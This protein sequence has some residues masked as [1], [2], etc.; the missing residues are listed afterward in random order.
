MVHYVSVNSHAI[1]RTFITSLVTY[2]GGEPVNSSSVCKGKF[3]A[4][5]IL[6][7][8]YDNMSVSVI[9]TVNTKRVQVMGPATIIDVAELTLR[10]LDKAFGKHVKGLQRGVR[11]HP[12]GC[13][14]GRQDPEQSERLHVRQ[15]EVRRRGG[16]E[17]HR[18]GGVR[19][20]DRRDRVVSGGVHAG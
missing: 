4:E 16:R 20:A 13:C 3:S 5:A 1:V 7:N 2:F 8:R 11:G 6:G 17:D 14:S 10:E 9:Y 18:E 19:D 15:A 12:E